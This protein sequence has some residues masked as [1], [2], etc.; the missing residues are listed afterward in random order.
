MAVDASV[1][2][3]VCTELRSALSTQV[4]RRDWRTRDKYGA[5]SGGFGNSAHVIVTYRDITERARIDEARARLAAI[6]ESSDDAI[7]SKTDLGIVKSW[8]RGAERL[9]G[10]SSEEMIGQSITRLL[11]ED[12]AEEENSILDHIR[13][14]EKV[15]HVETMRRTKEGKLIHVSLTISPIRD[16]SGRIVGASKIARNITERKQMERQ[17]YQGQKME[18]IGQLT[19]GIAHDFNNLLGI[20]LGNLDLLELLL[21]DKEEEALKRVRTA[22]TAGMRGADLIRRLMAFS[23]NVELR[24]V[25]TSLN[26]SVRNLIDWAPALGPDIRITTQLDE[27]LPPVLVDDAGLESALLNLAVNARDAMP[28]GGALTI[29]T[30]LTLLEED[31]LPVRTGELKPGRYACISISDTGHGMSPEIIEHVFEPFF[32]TKPRDKGTGLGLPMVYGFARQS[33]GTVRIYSE[34]NFGTTVSLYLPLAEGLAEPVREP[35]PA[36]VS[37]RLTGTVLVVD[38]EEGLVEIARAYLKDMGY[39]TYHARDGASALAISNS[40]RT[41]IWF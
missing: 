5:V 21:E 33:G 16:S 8:N 41:S 39:T 12:R 18:A 2:G 14:G 1:A 10:Y 19:G 20:I 31:Y 40:T 7:I 30:Q 23:S 35:P 29:T 26:A 28:H 32:T 37:A 6:V 13:R 15:D 38:D 11:P 4:Q 17:L 27:S 9:F 22:Q 24:A 25:A 3:G 34:V 36:R